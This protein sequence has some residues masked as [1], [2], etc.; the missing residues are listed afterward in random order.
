MLA[1]LLAA[2]ATSAAA[3]ARDGSTN[4]LFK[5]FLYPEVV[6]DAGQITNVVWAVGTN[7]FQF[8]PLPGWRIRS[9]PG[10]QR[11]ELLAVGG[12]AA[13]VIR[14]DPAAE[15]SEEK[16]PR[17]LVQERNEMFEVVRDFMTGSGCGLAQVYDLLRVER[18]TVPS[19]PAMRVALMKTRAGWIECTLSTSVRSFEGFHREFA[20][21]LVGFQRV[22]VP[23]RR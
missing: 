11:V 21:F 8:A 15:A 22:E 20:R 16:P 6:P 7:R 9:N 1:L 5:V 18:G 23:G 10:E 19:A 12:E 17:E 13:I 14:F 4:I 3:Q 2:T